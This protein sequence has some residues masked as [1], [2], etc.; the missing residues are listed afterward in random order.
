ME[1]PKP[2]IINDETPA[3]SPEEISAEVGKIIDE[4]EGIY[5]GA[6]PSVPI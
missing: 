4:E 5:G 3:L 2:D 1:N 6:N